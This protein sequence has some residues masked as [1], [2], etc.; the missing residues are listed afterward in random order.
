MTGETLRQALAFAMRGWP[1]LPCQPGQKIPATPHGY[2]DATTDRQQITEWFGRHPDWNLAIA[3]GAPGPDVLDV[4]EYGAA[5][6]GYAAFRKLRCAGLLDGT[7]TYVRTPS[8]GMHAYFTGSRQRNGHLAVHHLD[9]RSQGGYVLAP[10]S[11]IEGKPYQVITSP[12][13]HGGLD[14]GTAVRLLEPQKQEQRARQPESSGQ[15]LTHLARWVASQPEGNRN[16]GLFWAANRALEADPAADLAS[17]ADAA[18]LAGLRDREITRTLNS[19]RNT[20]GA[21]VITPDYQAEA[22]DRT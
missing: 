18:R 3:T 17:L 19:A 20:G 7:S 1:V 15:D 22:G 13:G 4:D 21:R 14:W 9:F 6:N 2:R 10:P 5:G 8:G 11:V 12:G 16:A